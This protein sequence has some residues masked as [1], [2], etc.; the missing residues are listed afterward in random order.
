[1][2]LGADVFSLRFN[3]WSAHQYLEYAAQIGLNSIMFPDPTFYDSLE[4]DYLSTVK[5]KADELGLVIEVGIDSICPTSTRFSDERGTAA[6]QL[7]DMLRV[8]NTLGAANIRALLGSNADRRT[9][10]SLAQHMQNTV[11]T[12]H[13]VRDQAMDLGIKIAIENHAGDMLG[14]ELKSL[15]EQ[16]GP[17]FVGVCIDSGNPAWVGESPYVTLDH[18][19]PYVLM[20]H[21]RDTAISPHPL[22]AMARWV[23]MGDGSI[24]IRNWSR[25]YVKK[26]PNTIFTLEII[27]SLPPAVLNYLEPA[28]WEAYEEQPAAEFARFLQLVATGKPFTAPLLTASWAGEMAPEIKTAL[29]TQQRQMMEKSVRFC[30]EELGL[31]E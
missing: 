16:A 13:A 20:S 30:R 31:G 4:E 7:S 26:C 14:Y 12:C 9:E 3:Q 29:A 11:A 23:A 17:D 28:Y 5:A 1:M 27:S 15:V 8:A 22:G 25:Q 24:D 18:V 6:E 10:T 21:I 19:A 2:K